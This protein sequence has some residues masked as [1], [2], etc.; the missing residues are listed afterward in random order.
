MISWQ[1]T[2]ILKR[3]TDTLGFPFLKVYYGVGDN[4][5]SGVALAIDNNTFA[6]F[7]YTFTHSINAPD[8]LP[9]MYF[10]NLTNN[11]AVIGSIESPDSVFLGTVSLTLEEYEKIYQHLREV[12][13]RL[14]IHFIAV[15]EAEEIVF[16][17]QTQEIPQKDNIIIEDFGRYIGF[18]P[19]DQSKGVITQEQ[20]QKLTMDYNP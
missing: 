15:Q 8:I 11:N 12:A 9:K 5:I 18:V 3:C 16:G 1:N 10:K 2:L 17:A 13:Y 4:V 19:F 20:Y 6:D 14:N 7:A